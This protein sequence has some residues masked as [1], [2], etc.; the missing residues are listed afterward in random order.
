MTLVTLFLLTALLGFQANAVEEVI[1]A[2]PAATSIASS[3]KAP[4]KK[5]AFEVGNL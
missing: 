4:I 1:L 2:T 5:T 3:E